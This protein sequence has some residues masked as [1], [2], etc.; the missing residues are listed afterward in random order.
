MSKP[1]LRPNES[2]NHKYK[3]DPKLPVEVS[4]S[5]GSRLI[6]PQ[7]LL[8]VDFHRILVVDKRKKEA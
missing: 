8:G 6:V 4:G 3:M 1:T 2:Y 7:H 5:R